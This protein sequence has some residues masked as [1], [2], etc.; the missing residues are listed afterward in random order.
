MMNRS[1]A[2]TRMAARAARWWAA[3][4]AREDHA[5]DNKSMA[6]WARDW[7]AIARMWDARN[8][9]ERAAQVREMIAIAR[10]ANRPRAVE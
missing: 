10:Q 8:W 6:D 7:E 1:I 2:K 3:E 9:K 5:N 4:V